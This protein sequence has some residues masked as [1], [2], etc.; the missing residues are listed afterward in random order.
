MQDPQNEI[1]NVVR[2]LCEPERGSDLVNSVEKYFAPN[3]QIIYPLFNSPRG[4]GIE[5][6]KAGYQMLRTLTYGNNVD[7]H[8]V[9][10]DRIEVDKK[11][12]ERQTGFI[13]FTENL[14][15]RVLPDRIN[16]WFHFRFITRIDFVRN[17]NDDKW[18]VEKQEDNLPT[19]FGSTGL[20]FLP[21]DVQI[22]NF[23]K[24]CTGVGTLGA[25]I[26]FQRLE[27]F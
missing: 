14:K 6:V 4:S 12:V 2:S 26:I 10:F 1:R 17:P 8:A 13:D 22:A 19:D 20:H 3:A 5:G 23:I 24:F 25:G 21:F 18:Y 16:P 9:A 7:F 27:L 11:G 15:I